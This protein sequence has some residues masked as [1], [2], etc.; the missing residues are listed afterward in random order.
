MRQQEPAAAAAEPVTEPKD[1][2]RTDGK[3][4]DVS[5]VGLVHLARPA[6]LCPSACQH[7]LAPIAQATT[8]K[9]PVKRYR[10]ADLDNEEER[11][12]NLML[13]EDGNE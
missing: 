2:T 11:Q 9:P 10:R 8:V 1:N 3:K 7:H 4:C 5:A 12:R 13:A 6:R